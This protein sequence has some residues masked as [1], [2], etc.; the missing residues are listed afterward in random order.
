MLI[1]WVNH[2]SF[3]VET[4][5]TRLMCDPWL[6]GTAFNDGW[7]LLSPTQFSYSDFDRITHI[8]F[9]HEHP[10]HFAP[11]N[12]RKIPE[13]FRHRITV[14]F[15]WT[16]DK[17]VI[18]LC[19]D[20][21]FQTQEMPD[22]QRLQVDDLQLTC[23]RNE[24]IDS[25]L[26]IECDGQKLLN[27]NDCVYKTKRELEGVQKI[28]GLPHVLLTQ[29]SYAN[30]A[31]NRGDSDEHRR[32]AANKREEIRRQVE[33]LQPA[34]VIPFASFVWFSH[35][36]NYYLNQGM[37]RVGDIAEFLAKDLHVIPVVLY[38]GNNWEVG[39]AHDSQSALKRYA[40]D[41]A[42][43]FGNP[44]LDTVKT[45]SDEE[46][47]AASVKFLAQLKAK[48][49]RLFVRLLPAARVYLTDKDQTAIIDA[50]GL[51]LLAGGAG[52][53]DIEM[54]SDSLLYC[55]RFGWG[56]DSLQVNGR[57]QVP[58]GANSRRFFRIFRVACLNSG[59]EFLDMKMVAKKIA[60]RTARWVSA[61]TT[62]PQS[63]PV[64]P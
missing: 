35:E 58:P 21:G 1:R 8:W 60:D 30:W 25:W 50:G 4:H 40:G 6:E 20:F 31:G 55:F 24:A 10:D 17:R 7:R 13:E 59:D 27:M 18:K 14:L 47:Q 56:S 48:N 37:N 2:A 42:K 11:P 29:F 15:H 53:G 39:S 51:R 43:V 46:L 61:R 23:G 64:N 49:N 19:K 63:R 22:R 45:A 3:V 5:R 26:A 28:V 9:S 52:A 32:A 33:V 57:F 38:P 44:P 16:K 36:Q 62:H 54:S 41:Y 12:L 34:W